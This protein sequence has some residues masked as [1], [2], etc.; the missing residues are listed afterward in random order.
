[1]VHTEEPEGPEETAAV[2]WFLW[3]LRVRFLFNVSRMQKHPEELVS[4][5]IAEVAEDTEDLD[6]FLRV[7]RDLCER[8]PFDL[9]VECEDAEPRRG[10]RS[11]LRL[12]V[13]A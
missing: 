6:G 5:H 11:P 12:R 8:I 4:H 3:S 7:L 9:L 1:M 13:S 10:M 2:L